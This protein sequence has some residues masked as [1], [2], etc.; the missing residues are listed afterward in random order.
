MLNL[1][2]CGVGTNADPVR[3]AASA[4]ALDEF[5]VGRRHCSNQGPLGADPT[6]HSAIVDDGMRQ[7]NLHKTL[8]IVKQ[9]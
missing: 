8:S 4:V 6:P 5:S 3:L 9:A 1:L 7:R 2:L